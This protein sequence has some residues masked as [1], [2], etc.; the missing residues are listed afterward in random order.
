MATMAK[1][2]TGTKRQAKKP[3]K[4]PTQKR[5][6]R[7]SAPDEKR[8][9]PADE[10][11]TRA[12]EMYLAGQTFE[13][14]AKELGYANRSSAYRAFMAKA[15]QVRKTRLRAVKRL[16]AIEN[17]RL[18]MLLTGH[19][20]L[21]AHG[22]AESGFVVLGAIKERAK[23]NGLYAPTRTS[24]TGGDGG[25]VRISTPHEELLGRLDRIAEQAAAS[26]ADQEAEPEGG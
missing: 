21:A 6:L 25:P 24:L 11:Q 5:G 14:I 20:P 7:R 22:N 15:E 16:I 19:M 26:E 13:A 18:D 23:I 10:R 4:K 9:L 3:A 2:R 8:S 1:Q 12:F 17:A